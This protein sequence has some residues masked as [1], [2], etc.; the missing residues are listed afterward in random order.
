M[1]VQCG[2]CLSKVHGYQV[3]QYLNFNSCYPTLHL[4]EADSQKCIYHETLI[5][6]FI[7]KQIYFGCRY[8]IRFK[9]IT[10]KENR[11]DTVLSKCTGILMFF[12][13][14]VTK[15]KSK[16]NILLVFVK[17]LSSER[18]LMSHITIRNL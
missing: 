1:Y 8:S 13:C 12:Y 3:K 11:Y 16:T 10:L 9:W 2:K 5:H 4:H 18:C 17:L 7:L 15:K 14:P 6:T